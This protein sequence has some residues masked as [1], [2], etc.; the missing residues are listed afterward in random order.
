MKCIRNHMMKHKLGQIGDHEANYQHYERLFE[1]EKKA[2]IKV[3]PK[4]TE[5]HVKPQKLQT[6]CVRLATQLF[7]HSVSIGL[8]VYRQLEVPR[9]ADSAGTQEF[10]L[11]LN[12]LFAS[13]IQKFLSWNKN[14]SP[15]DKVSRAFPG[16]DESNRGNECEAICIKTNHG[17][18]LRVT[19]M[20]VLSLTDFLLGQGV[21]YILT[22]SLNQDPLEVPIPASQCSCGASSTET[23]SQLPLTDDHAASERA[24]TLEEHSAI[25]LPLTDDEAEQMD[26]SA[27]RKRARE[28]LGRDDEEDG[29]R[30]QPVTYPAVP[31]LSNM[32]GDPSLRLEQTETGGRGGADPV[33]LGKG[34]TAGTAS[35]LPLD[36]PASAQPLPRELPALEVSTTHSSSSAPAK[37]DEEHMEVVPDASAPKAALPTVTA[38]VKTINAR[39]PAKKK[40]RKAKKATHQQP[41]PAAQGAADS[42]PAPLLLEP[43][44]PTASRQS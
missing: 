3:V 12:D 17:V 41:A 39:P 1:A 31:E 23:T 27:T 2:A 21:N 11:L 38:F 8:K 22:A 15:K 29:L 40:S 7:S 26:S 18:F 24:S 37:A 19:L 32:G 25:A 36:S 28:P 30:K 43:K 20:S 44:L 35:R 34:A 16:N 10:T 13:S 5:Y 6:M 14:G 42:P 4:L 33:D 9:F